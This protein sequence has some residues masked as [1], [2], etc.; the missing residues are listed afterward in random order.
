[1]EQALGA[2]RGVRD[3][4]SRVLAQD[5]R[6]L[7][8]LRRTCS[9]RLIEAVA[10]DLRRARTVY[11]MGLGVSRS[12]AAFLEFRLRRMRLDVRTIT[13]GGSQAWEE[14]LA[15]GPGDVLV[16]IGFFRG[17]RDVVLALRHARARGARTI[18][19]TDGVES[20]LVPEGD[21]LLA[22]RRGDLTVINSLVVPMALLNLLTVAV[23]L[24]DAGRAVGALRAWDALRQQFEAPLDGVRRPGRRRRRGPGRRPRAAVDLILGGGERE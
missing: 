1:M 12:L 20:P 10:R 11:I 18:V 5:V 13:Y 15:I 8:E 16:A 23:A 19:I 7:H 21:V 17:Y 22:A 24:Q 2:L 14:L 9:P 3:P 4:L 6:A